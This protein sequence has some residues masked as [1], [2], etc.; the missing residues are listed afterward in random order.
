MDQ[1]N[2]HKYEDN[3]EP[4]LRPEYIKKLGIVPQR[5]TTRANPVA[6]NTSIPKREPRTLLG[7]IR[8][9]YF[10]DRETGRITNRYSEGMA[11]VIKM[12][13]GKVDRHYRSTTD[14]KFILKFLAERKAIGSLKSL[15]G[16]EV[17]VGEI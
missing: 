10:E 5:R 2:V 13:R 11:M 15:I 8:E 17:Y 3:L 7:Y 14:R 16:Q 9:A 12:T 1:T 6:P 4:E